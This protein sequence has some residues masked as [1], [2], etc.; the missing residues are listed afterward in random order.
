MSAMKIAALGDRSRPVENL[1]S[2]AR[3]SSRINFGNGQFTLDGVRDDPI[4]HDGARGRFHSSNSCRGAPPPDASRMD[5]HQDA[6]PVL[7]A[8]KDAPHSLGTGD[9]EPRFG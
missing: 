7:A 6:A 8:G 9:L 5:L 2:L 1:F 4:R 3:G